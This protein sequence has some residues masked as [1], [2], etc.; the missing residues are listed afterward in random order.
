MKTIIYEGKEFQAFDFIMRKENALDII[1]GKKKIE[2]RACT[3]FYDRLVIDKEQ[4]KLN[5]E[6]PKNFIPPIRADISF[7]NF[8]NYNNSWF[9]TVRINEIGCSRFS[10]KEIEDIAKE[11]D[12]HDF[13]NEW[14]Q[15]DNLAEKE[16][17]SFYWFSIKEVVE[18]NINV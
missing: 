5:K 10:K 17:P 1:S 9:L 11:F 4:E 7:I 15:Y 13:D 12:F 6:D 3:P 2:T 14:Q 16:K 18:H 8:H